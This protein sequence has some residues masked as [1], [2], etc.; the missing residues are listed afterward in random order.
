MSKACMDQLL[1]QG[2]KHAL[3]LLEKN[4]EFY[5]FGMGMSSDGQIALVYPYWRDDY[6]LADQMIAETI[7]VLSARVHNG[8]YVTTGIVS[9]VRL[10]DQVSGDYKD[11]IRVALED[12]ESAPI[13]CYL[14]YSREGT[15]VIPGAIHAEAGCKVVFGRTK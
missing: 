14:P 4:G 12:A 6:P 5:P 1:D 9:N 11:A 2:A 7:H 8:Q 10:H 15:Q 3:F 13:T